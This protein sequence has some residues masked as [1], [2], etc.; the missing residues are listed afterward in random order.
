MQ[1]I[2]RI[3]GALA[4]TALSLPLPPKSALPELRAQSDA[5]FHPTSYS[6]KVNSLVRL[7]AYM[8]ASGIKS[9]NLAGIPSQVYLPSAAA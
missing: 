2:P 8:D 6:G 7:I 4:R 5:H 9:S 1:A 3:H